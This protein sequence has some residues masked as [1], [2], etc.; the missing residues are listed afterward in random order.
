MPSIQDT[1]YPRFKSNLTEKD[2]REVYTPQMHEMDWA[3]T[4]SRG[5]VQQ[6][7]LL[8]LLKTVQKL[9]FFIRVTD[10]PDSIVQHISK[11]AGLPL[12]TKKEWVMYSETRTAKRHFRFVRDYLQVQSFNYKAHQILSDTMETLAFSKDDLADLVNAGIEELIRQGYELPV[13]KTLKELHYPI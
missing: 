11:K 8:V 2:L 6:L 10:V 9:G 13:Y 5:Y 1:I 7:A 12:P 3:E 4:K